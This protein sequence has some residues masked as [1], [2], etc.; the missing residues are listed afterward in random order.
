[1]C[2]CVCVYSGIYDV[3]TISATHVLPTQTAC[4][5]L[6]QQILLLST[7][8]NLCLCN[9]DG[10]F[11]VIQICNILILLCMN[12]KLISYYKILTSAENANQL[13]CVGL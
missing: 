9:G 2:V 10:E 12:T 4:C 13:L 8:L 5:R 3:H 1:M 11:S 6:S 7:L